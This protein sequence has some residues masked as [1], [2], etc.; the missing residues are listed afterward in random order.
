MGRVAGLAAYDGS[1][2]AQ[3]SPQWA[4]TTVGDALAPDA[5][6]VSP[7]FTTV[8]NFRIAGTGNGAGSNSQQSD[9][10]QAQKL[11]LRTAIA[12]ALRVSP[13]RVSVQRKTSKRTGGNSNNG[14]GSNNRRYLRS[15]RSLQ[16]RQQQEEEEDLF[17]VQVQ[18]VAVSSVDAKLLV[19]RIEDPAFMAGNGEI[20]LVGIPTAVPYSDRPAGH[21]DKPYTNADLVESNGDLTALGTALLKLTGGA[22]AR[23]PEFDTA[24]WVDAFLQQ[25]NA[26]IETGNSDGSPHPRSS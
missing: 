18:V 11:K 6:Y 21:T 20:E 3:L 15:R 5:C 7:G 1:T 12:R 24:S 16:Q 22:D 9:P 23:R 26:L 19:R 14:S 4:A 2:A 17:L 13:S 10:T 8:S 25:H